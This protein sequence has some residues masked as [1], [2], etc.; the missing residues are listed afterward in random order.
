MALFPLFAKH[1]N[2]K[3]PWE[4]AFL[5]MTEDYIFPNTFKGLREFAAA[6]KKHGTKS[7]IEIYDVAMIN[8]LAHM[9]AGG[10]I[11]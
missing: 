4:P 3:F 7:E 10:H 6:F 2:F 5:A 8:N 9:I 1:S 11:H